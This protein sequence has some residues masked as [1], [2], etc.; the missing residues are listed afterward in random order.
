MEGGQWRKLADEQRE[1]NWRSAA[2][3]LVP[4]F[5]R[6]SHRFD[7]R[8]D[9]GDVIATVMDLVLQ[10]NELRMA[11]SLDAARLRAS[12]LSVRSKSVMERTVNK[13]DLPDISWTARKIY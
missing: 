2:A 1:L 8:V 10:S 6:V 9:D 11:G 12:I 5:V 7:V 4:G 3:R 13:R